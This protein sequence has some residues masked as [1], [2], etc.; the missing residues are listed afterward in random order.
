MNR[1]WLNGHMEEHRAFYENLISFLPQNESADVPKE[2]VKEAKIEEQR[3]IARPAPE[4]AKE[5]PVKLRPK[6]ESN[7]IRPGFEGTKVVRKKRTPK[8]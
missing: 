6:P 7:K 2:K 3:E 5:H 8:E 4:P 1:P